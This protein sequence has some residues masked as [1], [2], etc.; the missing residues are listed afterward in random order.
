MKNFLRLFIDSLVFLT[1]LFFVFAVY[2]RFWIPASFF[3]PS[4]TRYQ[5]HV[6][7]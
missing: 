7:E 1:F 6:T 4:E 2:K 5:N 3:I